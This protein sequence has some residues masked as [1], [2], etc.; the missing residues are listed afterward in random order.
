MKFLRAHLLI[1][2]AILAGALLVGAAWYFSSQGAAGG[3]TPPDPLR[4]R[5]AYTYGSPRAPVTI[6]EWS[7]AECPFCARL[8]PTLKRLVDESDG[9]IQWQYRHLPLSSHRMAE[10]AAIATECVGRHVGEAAFWDFIDTT[11]ASQDRITNEF[12]RT[13]AIAAGVTEQEYEVCLTDARIAE[14]ISQDVAVAEYYGGQGTPFSLI[15]FPDK[16]VR[17][18]RGALPYEQWVGLLDV[19]E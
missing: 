14:Q 13:E 17:P 9:Q 18:V 6:V 4:E 19:A 5:N 3:A 12:L 7:D 11:F 10:P 16:R 1:L 2:T 15:V 8:H